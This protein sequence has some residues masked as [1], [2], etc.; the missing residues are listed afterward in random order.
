MERAR[1]RAK[2]LA[3]DSERHS[4]MPAI[5][6]TRLSR[7]TSAVSAPTLR[8]RQ[9]S[10]PVSS[11]AV[12]LKG[13][14]EIWPRALKIVPDKATSAETPPR[15]GAWR[16]RSRISVVWA[17]SGAPALLKVLAGKREA[18][19]SSRPEGKSRVCAVMLQALRAPSKFSEPLKGEFSILP[20]TLETNS[21]EALG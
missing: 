19:C 9:R 16:K 10:S 6:S 21:R 1:S 14:G 12:P 20:R 15:R 4:W 5:C 7:A 2:S 17:E 11:D 13:R 8:P 18:P 3:R